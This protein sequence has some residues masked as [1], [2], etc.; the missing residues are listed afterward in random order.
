MGVQ[1]LLTL[2][3]KS[4]S[5]GGKNIGKEFTFDITVGSITKRIRRDMVL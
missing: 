2:R 5:Y 3:L 1:K 4:V